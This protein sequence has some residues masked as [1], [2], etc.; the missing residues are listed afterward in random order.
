MEPYLYLIFLNFRSPVIRQYT[1]RYLSSCKRTA[2]P[3]TEA[4]RCCSYVPQL[5]FHMAKRTILTSDMHF[6]LY[7]FDLFQHL[8]RKYTG[9]TSVNH[10]TNTVDLVFQLRHFLEVGYF[11]R[12][13]NGRIKLKYTQHCVTNINQNHN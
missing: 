6:G 5:H 8:V 1:I 7:R 10:N 11:R 9:C 2:K 13:R 12:D 4:Y 3:L